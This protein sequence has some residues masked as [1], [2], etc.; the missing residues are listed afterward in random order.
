MSRFSVE[1]VLSRIIEKLRSGTFLCS[2]NFLVSKI[3]MEKKRRRRREGGII[4]IFRP[5]FFCLTAE[6]IRREP[7]SVS[8][9]SGIEKF[10]A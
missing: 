7:F 5:S 3:F 4:M 10:Y 6:K 2:T 9:L 8:L 1:I